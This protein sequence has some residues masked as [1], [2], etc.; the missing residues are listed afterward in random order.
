MGAVALQE[1]REVVRR[2]PALLDLAQV[3][4]PVEPRPGEARVDLN[5]LGVIVD[6]RAELLELDGSP[7]DADDGG[8]GRE[9][10]RLVQ[11]LERFLG[12]PLRGERRTEAVIGQRVARVEPHGLLVVLARA[13]EVL[14]DVARH[15]ARHELLGGRRPQPRRR[16]RV[17]ARAARVSAR[18]AA[19]GAEPERHFPL[20]SELQRLA[21]ALRGG[22]ELHHAVGRDAGAEG[23]LGLR[24]RLSQGGRDDDEETKDGAGCQHS[25]TLGTLK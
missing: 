17:L 25:S 12:V 8:I 9:L 5:D 18:P 22:L 2:A 11:G 13:G 24:R 14:Q 3:A 15:A 21:E 4:P 16:Q 10:H 20:G 19:Q 7:H 1:L 23:A 6:R